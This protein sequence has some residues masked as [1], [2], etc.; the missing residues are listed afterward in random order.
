MAWVGPCRR[1]EREGLAAW[2][3]RKAHPAGAQQ[4]DEQGGEGRGCTPGMGIAGAIT[5]EAAG[6]RQG[7]GG[8]DLHTL[9][10]SPS[11]VAQPQ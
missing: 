7:R 9:L 4:V 10:V 8:Q 6:D 2:L 1:R 3:L 5:R 11:S